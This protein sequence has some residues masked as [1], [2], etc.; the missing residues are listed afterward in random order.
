VSGNSIRIGGSIGGCKLKARA[1]LEAGADV[2]ES[3]I[4]VGDFSPERRRLEALKETIVRARRDEEAIE[5]QIRLEERRMYNQ[6]ATTRIS[7]N[8][9]LGNMIVHKRKRITIDLTLF[10][11]TIGDKPEHLVDQ[12]LMEFFAKGIVGMMTQVNMQFLQQQ[13]NRQTIFKG[14]VSKLKDLILLTR[15]FDI[16]K[17]KLQDLEA[18]RDGLIEALADRT[19]PVHIRGS[20]Q[21]DVEFRFVGPELDRLED[22][23]VFVGMQVAKLQVTG[24]GIQETDVD[25][26]VSEEAPETLSGLWFG[27]QEG[28]VARATLGAPLEE[29]VK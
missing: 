13:K 22:G 10:Y 25:G 28:R 1:G 3:Q 17:Q 14:V 18:E 24:S 23:E 12:A 20:V 2:S 15:E 16:Q 8:I 21:P 27:L 9:S 6:M 5:R 19:C 26:L 7:M 11:K 4:E 29:S